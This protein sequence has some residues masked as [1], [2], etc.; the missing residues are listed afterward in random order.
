MLSTFENDAALA[1][2]ICTGNSISKA[3]VIFLLSSQSVLKMTNVSPYG[4]LLCQSNS[5]DSGRDCLQLAKW[6]LVF[7]DVC[8]CCFLVWEVERLCIVD[9]FRKNCFFATAWGW[10][11]IC[12]NIWRHT[13]VARAH[14]FILFIL[15][16][17][18][19]EKWYCRSTL[20]GESAFRAAWS[21]VN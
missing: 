21:Y 16:M 20:W 11:M 2:T 3:T 4:I 15:S 8:W 9:I 7:I 5:A 1:H 18:S 19:I 12:I 6:F 13:W 10:N 17:V 14:T